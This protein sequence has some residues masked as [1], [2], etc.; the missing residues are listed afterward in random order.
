MTALTTPLPNIFYIISHGKGR[1][2]KLILRVEASKVPC[3]RK[4]NDHVKYKESAVVDLGPSHN[5]QDKARYV[6]KGLKLETRE[7]E[8]ANECESIYSSQEYLHQWSVDIPETLD[9][10]APC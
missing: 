4:E 9:H 3:D 10:Y 1:L 2:L 6:Q 7:N 5:T 8:V